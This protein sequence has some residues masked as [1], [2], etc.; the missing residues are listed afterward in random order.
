MDI[1]EFYA[2]DLRRRRSEEVS[3]GTRW[4][5]ADEK[6][7]WSVFWVK[8]TGELVTM[9]RTGSLSW[10]AGGVLG[11]LM[12]AAMEGASGKRDDVSV[13]LVERN[14][15]KLSALLSGWEQQHA[16]PNGLEWL[17]MIVQDHAT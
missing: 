16:S 9:L 5:L 13:L 14:S 7:E 3:F 1:N 2:V 12:G 11:E 10:R 8:D 17:A 15:A 4:R 6:G